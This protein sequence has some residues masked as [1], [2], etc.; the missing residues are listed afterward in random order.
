MK[1]ILEFV[2][3]FELTCIPGCVQCLFTSVPML[4]K[5]PLLQYVCYSECYKKV[6]NDNMKKVIEHLI[7]AAD[8]SIAL[9]SIQ[10]LLPKFSCTFWLLLGWLMVFSLLNI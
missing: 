1:Q 5:F 7:M 8:I 2:L 6:E 9:Y 10:T 3:E 4:W